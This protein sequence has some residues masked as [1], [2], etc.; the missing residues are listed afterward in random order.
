MIKGTIPL[1]FGLILAGGLSQFPEFSQQYT[2]RVG[3]AYFELRDVADRFRADAAS[4]NKTVEQ[5]VK[6][7][8]RADTTF[9]RDRGESMQTVLA[10]EEYLRRHYEALTGGDGFE[11]LVVFVRARDLDI[12]ADAFGIYKPAMP[13]T[14]TGAAHAALGFLFGYILLRFPIRFRRQRKAAV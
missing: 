13:L 1:I 5:A 14:F 3:G 4:N 2:Q 6:E 11:Q 9:L 10:R 7:Y 8:S 12:A